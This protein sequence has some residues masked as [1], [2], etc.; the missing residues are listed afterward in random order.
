MPS[1][2]GRIF[3]DPN[4][5]EL[6]KLQ[7]VVDRVNS[8]RGDYERLSEAELRAKTDEFRQRFAS[9]E[10]LDDLMPEAFAAVREATG[11]A[12]NKPHYDVQILAGVVLH[13]GK[14]AEMKTG[15]GK[16][17][18]AVLALYLNALTGRG[19]HLVTPNDYL[20]RLG[21][22]WMGP[23]Y[24]MLGMTVGVIY[25]FFAGVYDPTFE[26]PTP[27]G[28]DRLLH[29]RP[30]TRREAYLADVIYG[31]N[32]EF[33]FDYLRDNL[34]KTLDAKV[35]RELYFAIVDE[36]D[37]ILIDEARTPLIISA[38]A[39]E[40]AELYYQFAKIVRQLRQDEDYTIDER[41][42]AV[43]FTDEGT[44]KVEK[45]LKIDNLYAEGNFFLA[46]IADAALK[47]HVLKRRD[48]DYVVRNN[49]V[50]IVDE[51][52]GRMM[53]GRRWSEGLHQAVE[54]KEG[55]PV[56]PENRTWATITFQNYFRLYEK[57]AGMTGTAATEAEEFLKIYGLE[58]LVVPTHR[59]MIRRDLPDFV[60]KTESSKF[61]AVVR[62][63]EEMHQQDRPVLVGTTSIEKSEQLSTLLRE[64]AITHSVLNAKYHEQ[65]AAIIAQAGQPGAVTIATNMA[66]RGTDIVLGSSVAGL[67]GLH[68]IGTE[69]HESRRI[70]NQLRGRA[71]RQGDPG[72]SRFFVSLEDELMRRFGSDRI[73]SIMNWL[74]MPEDEPIEHATVTK[75]IESAQVKVE[76]YNFDIR[77]HVVEY[78]D[79][80]NEQ[81]AFIYADRNRVLRGED[82]REYVLSL[83]DRH[84]N[85]LVEANVHGSFSEDWDLEGLVANLSEITSLPT[86]VTPDALAQLSREELEEHLLQVVHAAYEQREEQ[87]RQVLLGAH[88]QLRE[89]ILLLVRRQVRRL[90]HDLE[91]SGAS[92]EEDRA[93]LLEQ[94]SHQLPTIP[95]SDGLPTDFDSLEEAIVQGYAALYD[96]DPAQFN[97]VLMREFER[98]VILNVVDMLW[99][100]H[101]TAMDDLREGIGLRAFGQR[102]PLF[103]YQREA[104]ELWERLV[105][106]ISAQIVQN[107]FRMGLRIEL[108]QQ[109]A[110]SPDGL[111]VNRDDGQ[112][113]QG[114]RRVSS[115]NGSVENGLT[116]RGNGS[117]SGPGEKTSKARTRSARSRNRH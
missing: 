95:P 57:L 77:K 34:A 88:I 16:T 14:I 38:P 64:R 67:G 101:L 115:T 60:F 99:V 72:S 46:R 54:A 45:A 50:I 89:F 107:V 103:E 114:K 62:E 71:G 96:Q 11:R 44:E 21:G 110:A 65:E 20:A 6:R 42:Q 9:G 25:P 17:Q 87:L 106:A 91:L 102:N 79:V 52:T 63:I 104:H 41:T 30:A 94:V 113:V 61:K 81:R 35:Q 109:E 117:S 75:A 1:L 2:L 5:R 32:N 24:H 7:P 100:E 39:E 97:G 93:V 3:G 76:G 108:T 84:V 15:E 105:A 18:V 85:S 40:S 4:I 70:D 69:R 98:Q 73:A 29:W 111:Q 56:Q 12:L 31:T 28:D 80:M 82:M 10:T 33:G 112:A 36:V 66:G 86:D 68:I 90:A 59:P 58:T 53:I 49:E 23:I 78:D 48:R 22:G 8:L 47:A 37:N 26:D 74:K 27:H 19:C 43:S 55:L 51:F 83:L 92:S 13:Q 116:R